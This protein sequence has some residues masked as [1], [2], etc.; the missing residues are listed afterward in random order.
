MAKIVLILSAGKIADK[1]SFVKPLYENPGLL[2]VN[3]KSCIRLI[4]NFY[5]ENKEGIDKIY[6]ATDNHG[7]EEVNNEFSNNSL[8]SVLNVGFSNGVNTTL[9]NS[10]NN[11]PKFN[12]C[13]VNISTTIPNCIPQLNEVFVGDEKMIFSNYSGFILNKQNVKFL[14]KNN[15]NKYYK[16][17]PFTGVFCVSNESILGLFDDNL[18]LPEDDLLFIIKKISTK[19]SLTYR[20]TKWYDIGHEINYFESRISYMVSRSFKE[21]HQLMQ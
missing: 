9:I 13:I 5:L 14:F 3:S 6:I 2:P 15:S 11:L 17:Y 21:K 1:F 7:F 20:K 16:G 8:V 12:E 19:C 4:I 10:L 18:L